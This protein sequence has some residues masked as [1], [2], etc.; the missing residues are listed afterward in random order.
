M[1]RHP[2]LSPCARSPQREVSST[3]STFVWCLA[4]GKKPDIGIFGR[5]WRFTV[6]ENP[7][8]FTLFDFGFDVTDSSTLFNHPVSVSLSLRKRLLKRR[9]ES[10][11]PLSLSSHFDSVI[12]SESSVDVDTRCYLTL[13]TGQ[14]CMNNSFSF[15]PPLVFMLSFFLSHVFRGV[16]RLVLW[17]PRSSKPRSKRAMVSMLIFSR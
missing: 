5:Y 13:S 6:L 14:P 16:A 15:S 2:H 11:V 8:I 7:P 9:P 4:C 17:L 1:R 12:I 10:R 3:N